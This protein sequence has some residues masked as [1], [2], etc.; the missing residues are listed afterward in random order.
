MESGPQAT[1]V[2]RV[3]VTDEDI[4][5]GIEGD[6]EHCP[7]ARAVGRATGCFVSVDSAALLFAPAR[8]RI[9]SM[10]TP[11]EFG[12]FMHRFDNYGRGMVEPFIYDLP[13]PAW[14]VEG[15]AA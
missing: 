15:R 10:N 9:F 5:H 2:V 13:V 4:A 3:D 1:I 14:V 8:A 12:L 7:I 6:C 11:Q